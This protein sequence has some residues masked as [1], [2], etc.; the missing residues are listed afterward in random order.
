MAQWGLQ[1]KSQL[2]LSVTHIHGVVHV[3]DLDL[4]RSPEITRPLAVLE[5]VPVEIW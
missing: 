1:L 2:N 4:K 3:Y 5:Y